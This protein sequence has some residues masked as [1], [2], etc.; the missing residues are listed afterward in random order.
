MNMPI[1]QSQ[2]IPKLKGKA[3][4]IVDSRP[5]QIL[6]GGTSKLAPNIGTS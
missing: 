5:K 1:P 3:G 4:A 2:W 6:A